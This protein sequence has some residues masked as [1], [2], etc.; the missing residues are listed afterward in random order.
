MVCRV[1]DKILVASS[2][3]NS[4]EIEMVVLFIFVCGTLFIVRDEFLQVTVLDLYFCN[5]RDGFRSKNVDS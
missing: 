4:L 5:N 1:N 3:I 2:E